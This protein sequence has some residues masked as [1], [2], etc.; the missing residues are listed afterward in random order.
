MYPRVRIQF[1][2]F[3]M[4]IVF[5]NCPNSRTFRRR[6]SLHAYMCTGIHVSMR[7]LSMRA[8]IIVLEFWNFRKSGR[9]SIK[10]P[11]A[12]THIHT[13]ARPPPPPT[14]PLPLGKKKG[15][16]FRVRPHFYLENWLILKFCYELRQILY[17]VQL[18]D[19]HF[20][21]LDAP[22]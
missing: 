22:S 14:P 8:H 15:G 13:R 7:P 6:N 3:N 2:S 10:T 5:G 16:R 18:R 9:A 17:S 19:C 12:C 11:R 4:S 1:N 21:L 20:P